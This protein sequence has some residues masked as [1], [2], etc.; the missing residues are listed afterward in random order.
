MRSFA[1]RELNPHKK[2]DAKTPASEE[3]RRTS[4]DVALEKHQK[5]LL[6]V[7]NTSS[8][9]PA[10]LSFEYIERCIKKNHKLG[11]G[12]YGDV[13]LAEES[14]LP[15]KFAVKM[16]RTITTY[17]EADIK[18]MRRSFQIELSVSSV[19]SVIFT[20]WE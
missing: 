3:K 12:G 13:F 1:R 10:E 18:E 9:D 6:H 20:H 5:L 17:N 14:R 16:N 8:A 7:M 19:W 15:K 4:T 11:S 2:P